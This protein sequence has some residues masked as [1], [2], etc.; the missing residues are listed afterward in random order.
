MLTACAKR[1]KVIRLR[2]FSVVFERQLYWI[3]FIWLSGLSVSTGLMHYIC[4]H[5][6]IQYIQANTFWPNKVVPL[7]YISSVESN[8]WHRMI[9]QRFS[10]TV[11]RMHGWIHLH[12]TED[13]RA[14]LGR[15]TPLKPL[16]HW[17][18]CIYPDVSKFRRKIWLNW[19][20]TVL[21]KLLFLDNSCGLRRCWVLCPI[22]WQRYGERS[23]KGCQTESKAW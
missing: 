11:E 2:L 1:W 3:N 10:L 23:N 22:L 13:P 17:L 5:T 6:F 14:K 20:R 19:N 8:T 7:K 18:P 4:T 15:W 9:F 12:T 21:L 16:T